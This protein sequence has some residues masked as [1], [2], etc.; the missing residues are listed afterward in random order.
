MTAKQLAEKINLTPQA[1]YDI[2]KKSHIATDRLMDIQHV[3]GRD[4][5]KELSQLAQHGGMLGA[6][7]AG[8]WSSS[9][10]M[11]GPY[12]INST[13]PWITNLVSGK[14]IYLT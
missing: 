12:L 1:L 8:H 2:F 4:F 13:I 7:I 10:P 3:L 14:S 6:S 11:T 9:T 5:F